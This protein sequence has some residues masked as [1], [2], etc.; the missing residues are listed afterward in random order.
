MTQFSLD[1]GYLENFERIG[2]AFSGGLDSSVLLKFLSDYPEY[3]KKLVALHVNHGVNKESDYWEQFCKEKATELNVEFKSWRLGEL[4][5][6]S[7]QT[8]R[9]KRYEAFQE[10]ANPNDLIISGHHLDDQTE[11]ILFRLFRGTGLKGLQGINMISMVG[12]LNFYRPF[13]KN[14]KE[15]LF[16]YASKHNIDWI[17]DYSN[18]ELYFSRNFIRNKIIPEIQKRWPYIHKSLNRISVKATKAHQVLEEVAIEDLNRIKFSKT[19]LD[20]EKLKSLSLQRQENL[21]LYWLNN[22]NN[23]KLSSGQE[24]QIFSLITK[25][26]EGSSILNIY[27]HN[28]ASDIKIIISAKEIR[29]IDNNLFK[30]LSENMNLDWDLKGIIKISTGE[31]SVEESFGRGID[32]KFIGSDIK[33]KARVGGERC[34]PFGRS[35]SQKIKN[36]FQEFDVPDWKRDYIP[37]IYVQ[38]KIAAVGDLWV[39]DE[40][41]ANSDEYGIS[42]KWNHNF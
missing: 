33:I 35:K 17:E 6:T 8:L 21:V 41:H 12:P 23:I 22:F 31:L 24:D 18:R 30:P 40:F 7:E 38:E 29:V 4:K 16:N 2:V 19:V 32:K 14:K 39:C 26:L 15:D 36:L 20:M 11:T 10:W 27:K 37:I 1:K 3:Q 28:C 25:P 5:K 13:L 9:E 34:K 42:I